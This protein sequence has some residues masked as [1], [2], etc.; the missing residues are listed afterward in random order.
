MKPAPTKAGRYLV[1]AVA[2]ACDVT[3]GEALR[4]CDITARTGLSKT[5]AF[6]ILFAL[7]KRGFVE[8]G[9]RH[10]CQLCVRPLNRKNCFGHGAQRS[11]V[12]RLYPDDDR[13]S[14]TTPHL[15]ASA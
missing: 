14:P 10:T 8:Q 6:R 9:E 13:V 15:E 12:D 7:E 5:T 1:E 2:C 4:L 3:D 11:T